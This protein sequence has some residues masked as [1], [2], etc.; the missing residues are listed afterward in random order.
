MESGKSREP[1]IRWGCRCPHGR[2]HFLGVWP[3]LE[4]SLSPMSSRVLLVPSMQQY[5]S[6]FLTRSILCHTIYI[7]VFF[8]C[9]EFCR[10][11]TVPR[12]LP[13][14]WQLGITRSQP[15]AAGTRP[16]TTT[17]WRSPETG[18]AGGSGMPSSRLPRD[19]SFKYRLICSEFQKVSYSVSVKIAFS[20]LTLL[21]GCQ[22]E[23]P[24]C[25]KIE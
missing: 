19:R 11:T 5:N 3:I 18:L 4:G 8:F 12:Y 7:V 15:F 22:E 17:G 10:C 1:C 24:A 2:G 23:H 9:T 14:R 20:A 16:S 13:S 25:K 6:S 21:V